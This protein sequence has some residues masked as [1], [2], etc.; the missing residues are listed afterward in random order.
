MIKVIDNW[1][2]DVDSFSFISMRDTGRI[3]KFGDTI[4]KDQKYHH[5]LSAAVSRIM[6]EYQ[7]DI[8]RKKDMDVPE[9]I[10]ELT[11]VLNKFRGM[12]G[13]FKLIEKL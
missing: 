5:E 12:T 7:M 10:V 8:V 2:I 13:N 3:N 1:V 6:K 9:A 4:Y 11:D